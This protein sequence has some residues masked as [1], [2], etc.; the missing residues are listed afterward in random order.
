MKVQPIKLNGKEV[1]AETLAKMLNP[2]ADPEVVNKPTLDFLVTRM[3]LTPAEA[4]ALISE[5]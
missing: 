3:G 5:S 4:E 2:K 1:S